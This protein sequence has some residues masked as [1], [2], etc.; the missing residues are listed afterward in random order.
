MPD[1]T[2]SLSVLHDVHSREQVA[3]PVPHG[4]PLWGRQ[5]PFIWGAGAHYS[6]ARCPL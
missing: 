4:R 1:P 2:L 5:V 3:A 6:G